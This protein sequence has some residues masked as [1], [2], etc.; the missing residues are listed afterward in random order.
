MDRSS[1]R[2]KGERIPANAFEF[3]LKANEV[4]R[5]G[6][7]LI[8]FTEGNEKPNMWNSAQLEV[9]LW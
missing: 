6:H 8:A 1:P 7:L 2:G 4:L 5:E 9:V 3:V